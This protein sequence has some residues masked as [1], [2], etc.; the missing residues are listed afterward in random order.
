[1][2]Q[3]PLPAQVFPDA[4]FKQL[5]KDLQGSNEKGLLSMVAASAQPA[6][7]TWYENLQAIGFTTGLVMPSSSSDQVNIDRSGNGSAVVLAGPASALDPRDHKATGSRDC[8]LKSPI[9]RGSSAASVSTGNP[10]LRLGH[11]PVAPPVLSA[12]IVSS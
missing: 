9:F 11:R 2:P 7:R 3:G 5:T 10:S 8:S 12:P 1:V 4:L 6:V